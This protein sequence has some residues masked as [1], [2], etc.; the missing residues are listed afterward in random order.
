MFAP[1]RQRLIVFHHNGPS[2]ETE[3]QCPYGMHYLFRFASTTPFGLIGIGD[4]LDFKKSCSITLGDPWYRPFLISN[5][6]ANSRIGLPNEDIAVALN[7]REVIE[8]R[9][10]ACTEMI[11][12]RPNFL[13]VDFWSR[14]DLPEVTQRHNQAVAA[15]KFS[16]R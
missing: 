12:R 10:A 13:A 7:R 8:A 6:F 9:V 15:E 3:G 14:G 16:R 2:C 1:R 5:H 11:G 4:V